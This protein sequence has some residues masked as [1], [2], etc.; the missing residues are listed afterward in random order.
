MGLTGFDWC[1]VLDFSAPMK[2]MVLKISFNSITGKNAN[3][4]L[5][6]SYKQPAAYQL[7]IAA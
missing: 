4:T 6:V 7:A 2:V 1:V 5:R 3:S